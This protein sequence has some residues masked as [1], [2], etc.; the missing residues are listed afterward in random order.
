MKD[1]RISDNIYKQMKPKYLAC[2]S[3]EFIYF[4]YTRIFCI[5]Y[6]YK[7][8]KGRTRRIKI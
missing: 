2:M 7:K 3:H 4:I 8:L 5:L 1:K 6:K